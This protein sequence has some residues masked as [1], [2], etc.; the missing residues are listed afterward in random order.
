MDYGLKLEIIVK[1]LNFDLARVITNK[2]MNFD[3]FYNLMS[4]CKS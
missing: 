2:D 4:V 3:T 1:Q